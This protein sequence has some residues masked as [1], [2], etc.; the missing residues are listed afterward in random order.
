LSQFRNRFLLIALVFIV[1]IGFFLYMLIKTR[2]VIKEVELRRKTEEALRSSEAQYRLLAD[3]MKDQIWTMDM[4]LKPTYISPSVEKYRGFTFEEVVQL[5]IDKHLTAESFQQAM[6][7]FS[8]EMPTAL[9]DKTYRLNRTLELE[10]FRKDGSTMWVECKFSFIRDEKE[11]PVSILAEGRDITERRKSAEMLRQSEQ[12]YRLL[13]ENA[14]E[15]IL[16]AQ[17]DTIKFSNPSLADIL[18]YPSDVINTKP[19]SSFIHPDDIAMIVDRHT[20]R[21]R[22]EP[23]E[24]GYDFRILTAKGTE[25]WLHII[26]RLILWDGKPASLSFVMD[27]TERKNAEKALQESEEKHR[28]LI[29]NIHDIIYTMNTDGIFIFVSAAWT[30]LLGHHVSEVEGKSFQQFVHPDDSEVCM[31]SKVSRI[32]SGILTDHGAGIH[33]V[34]FRSRTKRVRFS[35]L[36]VLPGT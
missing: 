6:D 11:N 34:E 8:I 26:S 22:G 9:A 10:F 29:E 5:P 12:N 7:F 16:I 27:V 24:T 28:L 32:V 1:G 18:E 21:M 2:V 13:F 15:G 31:T 36:K 3:H 4:N 33:P 25:K 17:G 23:T 14:G 19:F 20:R 35:G 30:D